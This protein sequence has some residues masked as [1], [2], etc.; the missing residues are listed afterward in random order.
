MDLTSINALSWQ[1]LR[2]TEANYTFT[3]N[4]QGSQW[5]TLKFDL[6]EVLCEVIKRLRSIRDD[7][8]AIF[9]ML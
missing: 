5:S 6:Y 4:I 3:A 8:H 1:I 2:R 9:Q 7:C